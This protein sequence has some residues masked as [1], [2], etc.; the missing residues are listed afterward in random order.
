MKLYDVIIIGGGIA[1]LTAAI[2]TTRAKQR[3]LL[4]EKHTCGGLANWA[5]QIENFPSHE[6]I[7]GMELMNK[8]KN[9]I[10]NLGADV[11][12]V[13]EINDI[14]LAGALKMIETDEGTFQAPA[15]IIAT[16]RE[17]VRLP[18]EWEGENIHYCAICDGTAYE[19]D[20]VL[21]I[22]GGNS[23]V[24][25]A[26]YLL[27]QGVRHITLV[28][29]AN[30]LFACKADQ[31][32]LYSKSH[33]EILTGTVVEQMVRKKQ[34]IHCT[35]HC[36]ETGERKEIV[37]K[38]VFVYI[39]QTPQT[40]IFRGFLDMDKQGYIIGDEDMKTNMEGV[41]VAGDVRRKKY[42]LLTTAMNDAAVAALSAEEYCRSMRSGLCDPI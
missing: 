40:K 3:T 10:V 25:D 28:E 2:Y 21:V 39:G 11:F 9:Q 36:E 33:A 23:G 14:T 29:Q 38:G 35:L 32:A 26:L 41:F 1:G 18:A 22:G 19:N 42:R 37:V 31:D 27:N 13:V 12:E 24:G 16:G 7:S 20:D 17:P 30:R 4:L 8:V 34:K 6:R 15:L 5:V